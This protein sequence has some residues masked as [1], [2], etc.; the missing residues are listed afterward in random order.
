MLWLGE[1][2]NLTLSLALVLSGFIWILALVNINIFFKARLVF[3]LFSNL[4]LL[5]SAT[6]VFLAKAFLLNDFSIE[7]VA[8]NSSNSL[9]W[10]YKI[11]AIWGGHEG[12][13]L[14]WVFLLSLLGFGFMLV[15]KK[16]FHKQIF[17][18]ADETQKK[19]DLNFRIQVLAI[20]AFIIFGFL[21]YVFF[22][23]NPF[24]RFFPFIP[25]NGA[26]L[27][28][29]LQD[30]GLILHPPLL[31]M[32]YGGLVLGFS[33][34]MAL[35]L[36]RAT[37]NLL[38]LKKLQNSLR[39]A[40]VFLTLGIA[41]G[42]FWAYYE[43]GWGGW[44]FWDQV[45]NSALIPWIL[46]TFALHSG[47]LAIKRQSL[48]GTHFFVVI[49]AFITSLLGNFLVRS[50]I[51]S[52]VHSF[53]VSPTK[54]KFI[55]L[56]IFIIS[57]LALTAF[58]LMYKKAPKNYVKAQKATGALR[59]NFFSLENILYFSLGIMAILA[60]SVALGTW[61]PIILQVLNLGDISVGAPYFNSFFVPL[62][63]ALA[64][65]LGLGFFINI[66]TQ[67]YAHIGKFKLYL[68]VF[69]LSASGFLL[70]FIW[71]NEF[72]MLLALSLSL[73]LWVLSVMCAQLFLTFK[74]QKAKG[75][76]TFLAKHLAHLGFA[77]ALIGASVSSW[78]GDQE[79]LVIT[80]GEPLAKF[81]FLFVLNSVDLKKS[82]N[83]VAEVAKIQVWQD[84]IKI[85]DLQP[86]RRI[87][88]NSSMPMLETSIDRSLWRDIYLAL[89]DNLSP[90]VYA[91]KIQY[92]PMMSFLWLGA[93]FMA[94]GA[95]L[96]IFTHKPNK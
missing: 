12:S 38:Y 85:G 47:A 19:L 49:L 20:I 31:Y 13:L 89:G 40:W 17:N 58:V 29:M 69:A 68:I 61:Y 90:K 27:N 55:L 46:L 53:A 80:K 6:Q 34:S 15:Y 91:L 56:L 35:V 60:T 9:N 75:L 84:D 10:Y 3:F 14:F 16:K 70:E 59:V 76:L 86:E 57:I 25:I 88:T 33:I 50:G 63:L 28:P 26:D 22:L 7:Y 83:Y 65:L 95:F 93:L 11:S 81:G 24:A 44:W 23:G 94:L 37:Y 43:L 32:G 66:F 42:S 36:N 77:L 87:Y 30:I 48:L 45:E 73:S 79:D 54:G 18:K 62:I 5:L 8:K 2:A 41:L 78:G 51:L 4:F 71:V 74:H 72:K 67:M 39:F 96:A 1:I 21:L 52:S 82:Q 92:K 64:F